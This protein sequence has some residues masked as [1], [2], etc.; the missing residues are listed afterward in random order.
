MRTIKRNI[1]RDNIWK[2][3]LGGVLCLAIVA[4]AWFLLGKSDKKDAS[5]AFHVSLLGQS[6]PLSF[7]LL[8]MCISEEKHPIMA[9][10][11]APLQ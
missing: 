1:V 9:P 2:I 8:S 7:L 11:R 6:I 4:V 5:S 3:L 10:P